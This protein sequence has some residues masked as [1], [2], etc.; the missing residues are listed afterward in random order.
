MKGDI[1]AL[2]GKNGSGK[3]TLFRLLGEITDP[4]E[5]EVI[6][7]GKVTCMLEAGVGF[8]SEL[9]GKE[10]IYLNGALLG[11]A[12]KEMDSLFDRIVDFSELQSYL[13]IPIKKYSSGM[14]VRLAFSV[15]SF[16][17][18]DIL[19]LDEV[20]SLADKAFRYKAFDRI[21][22]MSEKGC[23]ILMVSHDTNIL[24]GLC[25]SAIHIENGE[26]INK[27]T[28]EDVLAGY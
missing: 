10:N 18:T 13:N 7:R 28:L 3:T 22:E 23:T 4:T 2:V 24:R 17:R 8:H 9:T 26:F 11:M 27:G 5:G 16:L 15:A 20:L 1:V 14:Y 12:R 25:K 19:L 6:I 21:K